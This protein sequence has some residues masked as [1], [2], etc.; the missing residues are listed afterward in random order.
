MN[1]PANR[2]TPLKENWMAL[3]EPITKQMKIDVRMN[4]KTKKVELKTTKHTE[5]EGALQ[6]SA[7]FV[8]AFLLGFEIQDAVALLRLDDLYLECFEVKDVKQTLKGEHMS[9]GIG[10]LAGKSGKTKFTIENATRTRIVIA[11]QHIR[12]LGSFQNIKIARDALCNLILGSPPGKV[13]SRLRSITAR[14]SE[15]F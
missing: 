7:D 13:Y 10:R 15:R 12:I 4:L 8:Q 1:V 2:F 6:K 11:D 5:D 14:L 3:Y 9:R